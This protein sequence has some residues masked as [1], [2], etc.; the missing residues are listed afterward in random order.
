MTTHVNPELIDTSSSRAAPGRITRA[1]TTTGAR[2][3]FAVPLAIAGSF[4]FLHGDAMAAAVPVPGG[5][6][7]VYFTGVALVAGSIGI[8]SGILGRSAAFGLAALMLTFVL[9]VHLPGL[10][11]P[12]MAQMAMVG[13]IKDLALAGGALALAGQLGNRRR[14]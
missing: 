5:I 7:W 3:L 10:G 1:L 8:L 11:N 6:F 12:Q 14:S 13:L 2:V 9:T 4:H